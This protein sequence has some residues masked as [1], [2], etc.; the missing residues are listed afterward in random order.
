MA[1]VLLLVGVINEIFLVSVLVILIILYTARIAIISSSLAVARH[2][3]VSA[4]P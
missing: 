2:V 3:Y 4:A 1:L